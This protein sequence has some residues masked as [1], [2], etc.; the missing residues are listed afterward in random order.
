[1]VEILLKYL[2]LGLVQDQ[3]EVELSTR[4]MILESLYYHLETKKFRKLK[5]SLTKRENI[6]K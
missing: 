6:T 1:M 5:K 3:L 4:E 2:E